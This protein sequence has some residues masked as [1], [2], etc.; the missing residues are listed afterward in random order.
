MS[1][2]SSLCILTIAW[3][4]IS[5]K[6]FRN[7]VM[8]SAVSMLVALLVFALAFNKAIKDD[9]DTS[10]KRLGA[11]IVIVPPEAKGLAEEFILESREKTFYM[12]KFVFESLQDLEEID[13]ATYHIYL[14]TLDSGCCSIDEGQVIVYDPKTD[15]IISPWLIDPHPLQSGQVYV[16]SYVYEFL[17]LIDTAKLFGQ[18][19]KVVGHLQQTGTGLDNGIFMQ[20]SDL[21]KISQDVGEGYNKEDISIIFL[22]VREGLDVGKVVA[23]IRTI[24]PRIGIMTRGDIGADVRA[25]L[26]DI[27]RIFAF[28][29]FISST[30][31]ILL[32]WST[33][34]AMANERQREVGIMRAIGARRGH[35]IAMFLSEAAIISILGGL[36]GIVLGHALLY[37]LGSDFHLLTKIGATGA[38]AS[39]HLIIS[40]I[41]LLAGVTVC[42]TGALVPVLRLANLEPLMAI[43]EE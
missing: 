41:S 33:F 9:I 26:A 35:I 3:K 1:S 32:A 31:A 10:T 19:V 39:Q 37:Y 14:N 4:G 21:D 29:I 38:S 43:K 24:N 34:S 30:L 17:G 22:K 42:L 25:T 5:R 11:D 18:G 28:T 13:K 40:A 16:G 7:L 2:N 12:N 8:I 36:L 23:K 20:I 15:F 27:I 6:L